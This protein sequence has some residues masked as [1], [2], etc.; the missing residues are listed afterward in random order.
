MLPYEAEVYKLLSVG[1]RPGQG[2]PSCRWYGL[3]GESHVLIMEKLGP[4]LS[5]IQRLCRGQLSLKTVLMLGLQIVLRQSPGPNPKEPKTGKP[6]KGLR[7]QVKNPQPIEF[8]TPKPKKKPPNGEKRPS[9]E[10]RVPTGTLRFVSHNVHFG[11]EPSRRD[12]IEALGIVLLFLL[13]GSLPWQ[14][15]YGPTVEAKILR[16]GEMKSGK[17]MQ[18]LIEQSP[19]REVWDALFTHCRSLPFEAKPDNDMLRSIIK[20]K[21]REEGWLEGGVYDWVDGRALPKGTLVPEEYK[22]DVRFSEWGYI[23]LVPH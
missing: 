19:G 15:I 7:K 17:V 22:L 14:G 11:R 13:H 2:I 10:G 18:D 1:R 16:I 21:L 12:D 20:G 6:T 9:R 5:A 4:D 8:R 23:S 3:D